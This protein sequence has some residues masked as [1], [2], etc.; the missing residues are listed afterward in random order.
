VEFD[1]TLEL[2]FV[3]WVDDVVGDEFDGME[4]QTIEKSLLRG[5][6]R[7]LIVG[8]GVVFRLGL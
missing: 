2:V 7:D 1:G 6:E 3:V 4:A 8:G 5:H